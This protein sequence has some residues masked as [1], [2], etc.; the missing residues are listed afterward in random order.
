VAHFYTD[1][2]VALQVALILRQTGHAAI[3]ARDLGLERAGDDTHLLTAAQHGWIL[4]THNRQHF[5]LLY[6]AWLHWF[7]VFGVPAMHAGILLPPHGLPDQTVQ[8][9]QEFLAAGFP[10]SNELY[11][12]RPAGGWLR[13]MVS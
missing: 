1:H 4:V 12:W 3:T 2:N 11:T 13:R 9:R 8:L 5:S 6:D 10:L 7:Q